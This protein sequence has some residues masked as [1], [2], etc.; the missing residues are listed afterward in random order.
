MKKICSNCFRFRTKHPITGATM[1]QPDCTNVGIDYVINADSKGCKHWQ[2]K[3]SWDRIQRKFSRHIRRKRWW[4][5]HIRMPIGKLR[6][7]IHLNWI[8][9]FDG[10]R[11]IIIPKGEP[12]CPRCKEYPYS[13]EQCQFCGQRF[14][15]TAIDEA[16]GNDYHCET[17]YKI[18]PDTTIEI[19]SSTIKENK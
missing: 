4:C 5:D 15:L 14:I 2:S 18:L 19:I 1:E 17:E 7:P 3:N 6:K 11:D 9:A 16:H 10:C 13:D 12:Q 8:D